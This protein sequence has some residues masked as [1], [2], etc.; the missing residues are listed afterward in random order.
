M[1]LYSIVRND[2][3]GNIPFELHN[4][5]N[6]VMHLS[7]RDCSIVVRALRGRLPVPLKRLRRRLYPISELKKKTEKK[8]I[9]INLKITN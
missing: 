6:A 2:V 1:T 8:P 3:N 4:I 7:S 5:Q 9:N